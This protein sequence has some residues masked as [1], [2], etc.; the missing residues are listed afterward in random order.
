M[1]IKQNA[2]VLWFLRGSQA[3]GGLAAFVIIIRHF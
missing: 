2:Y 1:D 3:C